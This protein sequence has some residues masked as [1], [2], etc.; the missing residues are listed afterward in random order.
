MPPITYQQS[1][2]DYTA[3]DRVK[4]AALAAAKSTGKNLCAAGR[5]EMA[6]TRGESAYVWK[7]GSVYMASVVEGVG[8]KNLVAD[9]IRTSTGKTYYDVVAH[10]TV[11]CIINDLVSVGAKP[12]SLHAYWCV[13]KS[14][15][16]ADE[17]RMRDL[18][19]GWKNACD[20]AGVSWG[21]GETPTY[22]GIVNPKTIDLAGAAVG[23]IENKKHLVTDKNLRAG[24]RIILLK[25]N[26]INANGL[27][28]A[29]KLAE[30]LP[31][32]Y[33]TALPNGKKFGP[34]LL[35]KMNIYARL[36]QSLFQAGVDI[37]YMSNITGHGLRKLMRGRPQ[38]QYIVEK[39]FQPQAIFSFIQKHANLTADQ[40]YE[41]FNMGQDYALFVRPNDV[42]K[43]LRV[44]RRCG[45]RGLHAGYIERGKKQVI[46]KPKN[47]TYH[48]SSL[49]VR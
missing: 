8:T 48:S 19:R 4:R 13:G 46:I 36:V 49:Q 40:M 35:T 18:I 38:L 15:W 25:S 33:K 7:Q 21:G 27:S 43:T 5:F 14:E 22:A 44:I 30:K 45:F 47:T 28:L 9:A 42:E 31:K 2:V 24:D 39:V 12:L 37:H 3:L 26:G 17:K 20:T 11:A 32:G 6:D 16:L 1:G 41:T 23:I 29:R 34:A 10:D